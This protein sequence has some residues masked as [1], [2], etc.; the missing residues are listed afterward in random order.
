MYRFFRDH[1]INDV[2]F[3]V[4]EKEGINTSSSMAGSKMEAKYKELLRTFWSLSK[5]SGYPVV[6]REFEQGI[7]L[8]QDDQRMTQ[9]E[10]N[11]PFSI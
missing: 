5:Q 11:R 9:N 2:G 8:I 6:L 4:E 10:L 7:S 3:N 1:G